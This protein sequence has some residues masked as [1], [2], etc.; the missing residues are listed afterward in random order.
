M[1]LDRYELLQ[2]KRRIQDALQD[3]IWLAALYP[4]DSHEDIW[5]NLSSATVHL[6]KALAIAKYEVQS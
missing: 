2:R 1:V 4:L 5:A 6:D 3:V